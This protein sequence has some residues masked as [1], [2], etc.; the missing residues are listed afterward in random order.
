MAARKLIA[1][2]ARPNIDKLGDP[3]IPLE[4]TPL[5]GAIHDSR[6]LGVALALLFSIDR[7]FDVYAD[8]SNP[9]NGFRTER[10]RCT[11]L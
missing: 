7:R 4:D 1:E 3:Q 10:R 8:E 9:I 5:R 2:R 6:A 11:N